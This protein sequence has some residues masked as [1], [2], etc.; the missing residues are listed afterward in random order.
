MLR[1]KALTEKAHGQRLWD[2]LGKNTG[3]D[4]YFLLER[5]FPTQGSNPCPLHQQADSSPLSPQGRRDCRSLRCSVCGSDTHILQSDC[6]TL[7]TSRHHH[8]SDVS[9]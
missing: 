2:F 4:C 7:I 6:Y 8:F 1:N 3:V 9:I 5:I